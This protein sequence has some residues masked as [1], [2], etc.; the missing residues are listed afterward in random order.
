MNLLKKKRL[1]PFKR[2]NF[3]T[4]YTSNFNLRI[5]DVIKVLFKVFKKDKDKIKFIQDNLIQ[6]PQKRKFESLNQKIFK[7]INDRFFYKELKSLKK[8]LKKN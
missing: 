4:N 8:Y 3:I 6:I 7:S 2:N 1:I 5:T